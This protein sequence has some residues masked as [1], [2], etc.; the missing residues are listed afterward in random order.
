MILFPYAGDTRGGS[1]HS[2]FLL[3]EELLRRGRDLKLAF[4]GDGYAR[5]IAERK[6]FPRIDLP[7]LG[8]RPEL[9]RKDAFR[10]GNVTSFLTCRRVVAQEA[11]TLVHVNDKRM[12]RT[13]GLPAKVSGSTLIGHWRS[14][15]SPSWSVDLGLRLA[16]R[17]ICVSAYSQD[18]L[19]AWARTKSEVVY[20]PFGPPLNADQATESRRTIRE[21]AGIPAHAGVI[22]FFGALVKRKRP[23]V[24][25]RILE[26]ISATTDGRPVF[27]VVCGEVQEP[28]DEEFFSARK[29]AGGRL[30]EAGF[31]NNVMEW[32]AACDVM[33]APA[34]EEPLARVA[35]EAQLAG[36]PVIVSS[37]GGLREVIEDGVSGIVADPRDLDAWTSNVRRILDDDVFAARLREG[38]R[39][40]AANLTIEKHV[41]AIEAIYRRL[42]VARR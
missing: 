19:P 25:L 9:A 5:E 24:L 4:H 20:N 28:P 18:L 22:G 12:I 17:I 39:R 26:R 40:A 30:V 32:M 38:G 21:A 29:T 31:V 42:G 37:D 36:L 13:W 27:G 15:Y 14:V 6:H 34:V 23:H 2:S 33:I 10:L 11:A 35:V 16:S 41:D 8:A 3:I 7:A 1:V